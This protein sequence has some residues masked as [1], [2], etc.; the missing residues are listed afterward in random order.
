MY[1]VL[2]QMYSSLDEYIR[3][4]ERDDDDAVTEERERLSLKLDT[5]EV[6]DLS[7]RAFADFAAIYMWQ[8]FCAICAGYE[9]VEARDGSI[10]KNIARIYRGETCVFHRSVYLSLSL[11]PSLTE[12]PL[13]VTVGTR[14]TPE[15]KLQIV[16]SE[17]IRPLLSRVEHKFPSH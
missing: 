8:Y 4:N 3:Y 14:V 5:G 10:V 17:I 11:S 6:P 15:L 2:V 13:F 16:P 1:P 9:D 12:Y 7:A